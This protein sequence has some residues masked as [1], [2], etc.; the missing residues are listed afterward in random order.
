M[1]RLRQ[2]FLYFLL[3]F[4][5]IPMFIFLIPNLL[6]LNFHAIGLNILAISF[7][8]G[9]CASYSSYLCSLSPLSS[10]FPPLDNC[11]FWANNLTHHALF[12]ISLFDRVGF[13]L[14]F[15]PAG[16]II[17]LCIKC[18]FVFLL[19]VL[20][21]VTTPKFKLE[22]ITKLGWLYSL[23]PLLAVFFSYWLGFF[24]L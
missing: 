21:R 9:N 11:G 22:T 12:L 3:V 20:V 5:F 19:L 1:H 6:F 23:T 17:F 4:I 10:D 2:K 16:L 7:Y 8:S 13:F 15:T 14:Q 24:L 18:L